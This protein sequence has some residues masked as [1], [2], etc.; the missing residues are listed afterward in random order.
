MREKQHKRQKTK[1]KKVIIE[2][3]IISSL[4]LKKYFKKFFCLF[5]IFLIFTNIVLHS[6]RSLTK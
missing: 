4:E 2:L 3:N 1:K 5:G 6:Q